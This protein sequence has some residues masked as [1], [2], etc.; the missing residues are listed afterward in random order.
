[1]PVDA[2]YLSRD[3]LLY[4]HDALIARYGGIRG[5]R[6]EGILDSCLA[7][8]KMSVFDVERF[9]TLIEKAAAYCFF[10]VRNH[11]FLDGNKRT[12]FVAALHFLRI[13]NVKVRFDE[14]EMYDVIVGIAKGEVSVDDLAA[15]IA[16]AVARAEAPPTDGASN[17]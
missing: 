5:V 13:N 14:D 2:T 17:A 8:P 1:V 15:L 6:D 4:L 16:L 3:D 10:V 11:P 7:Q 12:G 9:P